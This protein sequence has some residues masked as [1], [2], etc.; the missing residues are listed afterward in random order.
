MRIFRLLIVFCAL[1]FAHTFVSAQTAP[2]LSEIRLLDA[3]GDICCEDEM[4]RL[5]AL[6]IELQNSPHFRVY[7]IYYGGRRYSSCY[8]HRPRIPRRGEA[9]A[10]AARIKPY[11]VNQR[12]LD[13]ERIVVLSGG[14]R[15]PWTAELW[16]V[17]RGARPPVPTPTIQPRDIRYRRG[18]VTRR[19][20]R[21]QC[22]GL[23]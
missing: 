12:G 14:F 10:R 4:A 23:G 21:Q 5:D 16:I 8:N 7:I 18:R 11:L 15:E 9:E 22:E 2:A 13:S 17:P 20:F 19:E 6:A 3:Y 1:V